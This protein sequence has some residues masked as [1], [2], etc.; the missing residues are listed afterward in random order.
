MPINPVSAKHKSTPITI[1]KYLMLFFS[2]YHTKHN[3]LKGEKLKLPNVTRSSVHM[4]VPLCFDGLKP[5]N[6]HTDCDKLYLPDFK[7]RISLKHMIKR[8]H[9]Y[10]STVVTHQKKR[11]IF[12]MPSNT[13]IPVG[14]RP[15]EY[16]HPSL[17]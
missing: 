15:S 16:S 7:N 14:V 10:H 6:F 3:K 17:P 4:K 5:E 2:D 8:K 11:P 13:K 9:L 12:W 1:F